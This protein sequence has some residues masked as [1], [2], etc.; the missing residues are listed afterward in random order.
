MSKAGNRTRLVAT[1][2]WLAVWSAVSCPS[3]AAGDPAREF[4]ELLSKQLVEVVKDGKKFASAREALAKARLRTMQSLEESLIRIQE[5]NSL[6]R[7][8]WKV[9]GADY[10]TQLFEGV[11]A[12]TEEAARQHEDRQSRR[13]RQRQELASFKS[14]VNLQA[15]ELLAASKSLAALARPPSPVEAQTLFL[16]ALQQFS[17]SA[18]QGA[19][20]A[21]QGAALAA[22]LLGRFLPDRPGDKP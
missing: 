20:K 9:V 8:A 13:E 19:G 4:A 21:Q 10:R 17:Q 11:I 14:A 6:D 15:A 2:S 3:V 16:N 18:D 7:H 1:F 12:A 5:A 22:R